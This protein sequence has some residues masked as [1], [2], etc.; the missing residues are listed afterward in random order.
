MISIVCPFFNEET[1]IETAIRSMLAQLASLDEPWELIVVNDGSRDRSLEIARAVTPDNTQVRVVS[2][3][4]NR[5][6]GYALRTGMAAARGEIVVTTEIDL[7]WGDD[8]VHRLVAQLRARPDIDMV[9][10]SPHLPGGGYANVPWRRVFLSTVGNYIIRAGLNPTITMNTG[11]TRAYRRD[12]L[13]SLPLDED[14]KELHLEIINKALCLGLRIVE[15][16]ATLAWKNHK[17]A[18]GKKAKRHSSSQIGRIMQT[19]LLFSLVAAPFRYLLPFS[20]LLLILGG[21]LLLWGIVNWLTAAPAIYLWLAAAA[22]ETLGLL[23]AGIGVLT[24]Q[25][26]TIQ[27]EL[28]RVRRELREASNVQAPTRAPS[29]PK[30]TAQG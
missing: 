23:M 15:I 3:A 9:V 25:G 29:G 12:K 8:I 10:A 7:S 27:R 18:D 20:A 11:M 22:V 6:R 26:R 14:G 2:Y 5:G 13:M 30:D 17:L 24:H 21:V 19:H 4:I 1:I 16:P 28:W